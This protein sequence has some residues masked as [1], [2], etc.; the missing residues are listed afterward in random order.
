MDPGFVKPQ[1]WARWQVFA[2]CSMSVVRER[3][4]FSSSTDMTSAKVFRMCYRSINRLQTLRDPGEY[5]V[6]QT[7]LRS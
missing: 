2:T 7:S 3:D 1:C 5:D 6:W 4:S